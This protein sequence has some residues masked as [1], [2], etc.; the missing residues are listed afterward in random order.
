MLKLSLWM[1]ADALGD[2]VLA[3]NLDGAAEV[4]R[5]DA[6]L[7]YGAELC[8]DGGAGDNVWLMRG[9]LAGEAPD[10]AA[11]IVCGHAA[12]IPGGCAYIM[13]RP[14]ITYETALA[15]AIQVFTKYDR[16]YSRLR[17]ELIGENPELSRICKIGQELLDNYLTLFNPEHLLIAHTELPAAVVDEFLERRTDRYYALS[18]EAYLSLVNRPD[19]ID[20][21]RAEHAAYYC[22]EGRDSVVLYANVGPG[23]FECRLTIGESA[24]PFRRSD[25]QLC[26]I[27]AQT[28]LSAL[29]AGSAKDTSTQLVFRELMSMLADGVYVEDAQLKL[30]LGAKQW[31]RFDRFCCISVEKVDVGKR[32]VASDRYICTRIEELLGDACAFLRD[33]VIICCGRL[34]ENESPLSLTERLGGFFRNS[35]FMLGVSREFDDICLL[36]EYC[37]EA[38]AAALLGRELRPGSWFHL[39]SDYAYEHLRRF[40]AS[41]LPAE[42]YCERSAVELYRTRG[43]AVDYFNTLRVYLECDRNLLRTAELLFIHRT[44]LFYRLKQIK[45]LLTGDLDDTDYKLRLLLSMELLAR[46]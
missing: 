21:M 24:R 33:G 41:V 22:D 32:F 8:A 10:G 31:G 36:P 7:P 17:D 13:L 38:D 4:C 27:V 3:H 34:S 20:D 30:E 37:G 5:F 1:I 12:G 2:S 19:H 43:G 11:V 14:D 35:V 39:F 26:E 16:W 46:S 42:H 44:T 9:E 25:A 6:V 15:L 29:R 18:D 45:K 40:G 28:L 23:E